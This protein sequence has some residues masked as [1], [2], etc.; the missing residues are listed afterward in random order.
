MIDT[1]SG[2]RS[3][4][5]SLAQG[6][7]ERLV[8]FQQKA[9]ELDRLSLVFATEEPLTDGQRRVLD[10]VRTIGRKRLGPLF[11]VESVSIATIYQR[12]LEEPP[13]APD[14]ISVELEAKL[15]SSGS[16]LLVGPV[17]LLG[18]YN[19]LKRYRSEAGD[20]DQLYEKNVRRFLGSRGKVNKAMQKTL[21]ENPARFGLYNNGITLVVED[22]ALD[23]GN[24]TLTEPFVVNGCQTTRT[25]WEVFHQQLESGGTGTSKKQQDWLDGAREGVVVTKIVKVGSSGENLLQDITRYTNSQNAVREKDFLALTSDFRTMARQMEEGYSVY[26]ET[27]RGGWESR[28]A[29]QRQHPNQKQFSEHANA[30]DLLKVYGAGWLSEPGVAYGRNAAFLPNGSV[31]RR[32][33]GQADGAPFTVEDFYAAYR[34]QRSADAFKFGRGAT[35]PSRRQTRFLFYMVALETLKS[36]MVLESLSV[37]PE[38]LTQALI[39]LYGQGNEDAKDSLMNA[40]IE[41]IDECMNQGSGESIFDEPQFKNA[42]NNDLNGY[43]KWEQI[44]KTDSSSPHLRTSITI[45][46]KTLGRGSPSPRD[47]ILTAVQN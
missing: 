35:K 19:F 6:L 1:L 37:T 28:R 24:V 46:R 43:L 29:Y 18:L 13:G 32:I 5:S 40:A 4:L 44:G 33:F 23:G 3:K 39:K 25:I 26:L 11:D 14:R 12:V 41:I 16:D 7:Q 20:L 2:Q 47:L 31:F 34:L 42:F 45:T 9:G 27:Q 15:A 36:L 22:F 17:S 30:F 21:K 38:R 8:L 10:D